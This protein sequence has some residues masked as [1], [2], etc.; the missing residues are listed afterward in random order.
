VL[1]HPEAVVGARPSHR[2]EFDFVLEISAVFGLISLADRSS[3]PQDP[4]I[5]ALADLQ[6]TSPS[7]RILTAEYVR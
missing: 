7:Q 1:E 4:A 6:R 3:L 5:K 2:Q